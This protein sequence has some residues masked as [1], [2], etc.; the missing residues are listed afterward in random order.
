MSRFFVIFEASAAYSINA[1]T[2]QALVNGTVVSSALVTAQTGIGTSLLY[3]ELD[4][5]SSGT[6]PGALSFRFSDGFGEPR[7]VTIDRISINGQAIDTTYISMLSLTQ[8]QSSAIASAPIDF[9]FGRTEPTPVDIGTPDITGTAGN[10][11]L[12]GT[13]GR[14]IISAAAGDD[15][16]LAGAGENVVSGGAGNDTL[17]GGADNDLLSG[18][19]DSDYIMGGAGDDLLYGGAGEDVLIG[20]AGN[21]VL[22]GGADNDTLYGDAGN[23]VLYGE[24]GNDE[25]LGNAG[26]DYLYGDAGDDWMDGGAGN[27]TMYGDTGADLM[28]GGGGD[29][30]MYGEDDNDDMNGG[31]GNDTMDGGAGIDRMRGGAGNDIMHGGDGDDYM[32]GEAGDDRLHGDGGL[33]ALVGGAGADSMYGGA[34]ND[35]L[36]GNGPIMAQAVTLTYNNAGLSYSIATNSYYMVVNT[37]ATYAAALAA[38]Q[39]MSLNGV[40]GSLVTI[41]SALENVYVDTLLNGNTGWLAASDSATEGAWLWN[42]G[43]EAGAQFSSGTTA[44]NGFFTNWSGGQP[45]G[46]AGE[47]NAIMNADGTWS[48]IAAGASHRYVIKWDAGVMND[49]NAA[50]TLY[51]GDD[52]DIIFGHGGNDLLYGG[53]GSDR[54]WG[55]TGNDTIYAVLPPL[56]LASTNFNATTES[57]TYADNLF[58]GTGGAYVNGTRNTGDGVN[59]NGSLEILFDGTNA[60]AEGAMSGGWNLNFNVTDATPDSILTFQFKVIRAGTYETNED[61]FV[62][63]AIDGTLKGLNGNDYVV[64]YESD[65]DNP[66]YDS[67]WIHVSINLGALDAGAHI[68]TLGGLVEGKDAANE[69]TTIRFDNV[70][71]QT[72]LD[73]DSAASHYIDG[74]DGIDTIYGS[75]GADTLVGGDGDDTIYSGSTTVRSSADVLTD[76]PALSYNATTN[77]FYQFVNSVVSW[78]AGQ[79]AATATLIYGVAGHM[80]HSN[81]ATENAYLDSIS[82][83]N[84]IWLGGTD[85]AVNGEWR[86]IGGPDDGTQFW[87]GL[88]A[89]SPVGGAYENWNGGEP[90]DYNGYESRLQMNNGGGW[91]DQLET[92]TARYVIEWEGSQILLSGAPTTIYAGNGNDTVHGGA[93]IDIIFGDG[94][95]DILNGNA[96]DDIITGGIGADIMNGGDGAD[97]FNL[98]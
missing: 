81:S 72:N 3:F 95:A 25:L 93:G 51:G 39:A 61:S 63:V 22:N 57:F 11:E 13:D 29:D 74:G 34:G 43:S 41:G 79:S 53:V 96:G 4:F 1:P 97:I 49:D 52:N 66:T 84:A 35:H 75:A 46:G 67:G 69:D 60:T 76:Y 65:G 83:A 92:S 5:P 15:R 89:G 58:G 98:A 91:N 31:A 68:L 87:Q 64:R 48:D 33:D 62:Y 78:Q 18:D 40:A 54:I 47:N 77:S 37:P 21:D 70:V 23:D 42:G 12:A 44:T 36:F 7:T 88:A 73:T 38:A 27:D 85:G 24:A 80:A 50:D 59:G 55:G 19:A 86:W 20:G 90:N 10:D 17:H 26:N 45:N 82:G 56:T 2:I 94:G 16:V 30:V 14:D 9:V 32:L 71:V 6:F 8:G 28:N